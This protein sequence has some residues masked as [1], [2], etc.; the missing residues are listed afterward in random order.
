M[1]KEILKLTGLT[2]DQF[3]KMYPT[4]AAFKAAY[5]NF[6]LGGLTEAFP[7]IATADNFFSY[8]VPVPPTIHA[9]GGP[10]YPQIQTE[11]QFFSP[12][13][14]NSNNAYAV[15]GSYMEAYPQ[16][17]VYP[18][19]PVGGSAFYA[20]QDGGSS[21][22]EPTKDQT[23]YTQKMN[24]FFDKLR[25][26][27]YKNMMGAIMNTEDQYSDGMKQL[28]VGQFGGRQPFNFYIPNNQTSWRNIREQKG[29]GLGDLT[30][31]QLEAIK[32]GAVNVADISYE[33]R[34]AILPKNRIKSVNVKFKRQGAKEEFKGTPYL[35]PGQKAFD[36]TV[37]GQAATTT[38]AP[39]Q[40]Q[41]MA[42]APGTQGMSPYGPYLN[43]YLFGPDNAP[44]TVNAQ[45][46]A[47]QAQAVASAASPTPLAVPKDVEL[48]DGTYATEE[49]AKAK[50]YTKDSSGNWKSPGV[51]TPP[52]NTQSMDSN[53]A[54]KKAAMKKPVVNQPFIDNQT[55]PKQNPDTR[56]SGE[57]S[58]GEDNLPFRM[59]G[60]YVLPM[61]QGMVGPSQTG[62][63]APWQRTLDITNPDNYKLNAEGKSQYVDPS[64]PAEPADE[65]EFE[66]G[67]DVSRVK[68]F[69]EYFPAK[70][71]MAAD[72][73]GKIGQNKADKKFMRMM[74]K[75]E[76]WANSMDQFRGDYAMNQPAGADFR[77]DQMVPVG[78]YGGVMMYDMAD[79]FFLTPQ[80]L[81][82]T[83][84]RR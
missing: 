76:N 64:A 29:L 48:D 25:Q 73:I 83:Q 4:E 14:S 78:Q 13:Y 47:Q 57:F 69:D 6:K 19:G 67:Y 5:P 68:K 41:Q 12:V 38:A 11:A 53:V 31:E 72:I 51:S 23:F 43:E 36:P 1:K 55:A 60:P 30:P 9:Y 17:K 35:M 3:Y 62:F 52:S 75:P 61:Y 49:E 39:A 46:A 42:P 59:G 33:T 27:S 15:G 70:V 20:M 26:N 8:G 40:N 32:T 71:Q 77:P 82:K 10:I 66:V 28:S 34:R 58:D 2:E 79:L 16:A 81:K 54:K 22:Q 24:D 74:M 63:Q 50:G 37:P 56:F 84:S 18:Q 44:A 45:V 80:M 7:Q 65:E 21:M